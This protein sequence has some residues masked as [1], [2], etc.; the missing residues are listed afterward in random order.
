MNLPQSG[1][2]VASNASHAGKTSTCLALIAAL[3]RR[4]L[5]IQPAKSGPD[6]IDTS[7][8]AAFAQRPCV[9][10]DLWLLGKNGVMR[11]LQRLQ[12]QN[13]AP[14]ADLLLVEGAMG[15]YDG[16]LGS[17]FALARA[18]KLPV[19]LLLN[20]Q[21]MGE[22]VAALAQGFLAQAEGKIAF[23]GLILTHTGSHT[24]QALLTRA[25]RRITKQYRVP[26]LGFLPRSG[27]PQIASRHLGLVDIAES[28]PELDQQA[29]ADWFEKNVALDRLLKNLRIPCQKKSQPASTPSLCV[30]HVASSKKA[31][32]AIAHDRAFSFCYADLPLFFTEQGFEVRFFS[33]LMDQALPAC[34]AIYLPGGYPELF[35]HEL[36]ANSSMIKSLTC[37]QAENIPIYGECGGY[38]YLLQEL[39]LHN[40]T[41]VPMAGL[42]PGK[43]VICSQL[44]G[45][46]YRLGDLIWDIFALGQTI[47]VRG[48]EFHYA[49][50]LTQSTSPLWLLHNKQKKPLGPS[51]CTKKFTAGSFLH[52]PVE[53]NRSFWRAWLSLASQV[54]GRTPC[55]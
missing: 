11:L 28:L 24:H 1:F 16:G 45:L 6:F 34:E 25:L 31:R 52:L 14:A 41:T 30:Q 36:A 55:Q 12:R 13:T 51:G 47:R 18:L 50:V 54:K 38:L 17:S 21:G 32:I 40:G 49:R 39:E 43:A 10:L 19:L 46:G 9:N 29:M 15:L 20:V 42:L 37:A 8:L 48:H 3:N 7:Y 22:S 53:G 35:A 2:L 23:A 27:S 44:Q 4:G 33:P 5:I 26:L